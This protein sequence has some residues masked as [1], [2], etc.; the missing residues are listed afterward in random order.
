MSTFLLLAFGSLLVVF[1]LT[2]VWGFAG[3]NTAYVRRVRRQV[4]SNGPLADALPFARRVLPAIPLFGLACVLSA[5][6]R[7]LPED[8]APLIGSVLS[9]VVGACL[10]SSVAVML[11]PNWL[12]PRWLTNPET[13]EP[14]SVPPSRRAEPLP[15]LMFVALEA[16]LAAFVVVVFLMAAPVTLASAALLGMGFLAAYQGA[17]QRRT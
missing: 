12:E 14:S 2:V 6:T 1:G 9:A 17:A 4:Q 3:T 8:Q 11:F 16:A 10:L 7:L 15:Q 13:E 5:V